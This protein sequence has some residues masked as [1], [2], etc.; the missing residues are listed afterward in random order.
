MTVDPRNRFA[1]VTNLNDNNISV[2]T[3]DATSGALA[4]A[5]LASAGTS[6]VAITL[7]SAGHFAYVANF[8]SDNVSVFAVDSATGALTPLG[9]PVAA[10]AGPGWV[11]LVN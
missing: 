3:I 10:D 8:G 9:L 5:S 11:T 4:P 7:D 2:Y 1:Y 6:P